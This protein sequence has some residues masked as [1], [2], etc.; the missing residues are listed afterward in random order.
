MFTFLI[1]VLL[2]TFLYFGGLEGIMA[3]VQGTFAVLFNIA[4][5]IP[6]L[7]GYGFFY[8]LWTLY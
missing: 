7:I 8:Y 1:I 6:I 4:Y 3:L 5:W 2:V